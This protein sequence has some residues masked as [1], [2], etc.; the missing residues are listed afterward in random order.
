MTHFS[1][2]DSALQLGGE[3]SS[4]L[5]LETGEYVDKNDAAWGVPFSGGPLPPK[6]G[7]EKGGTGAVGLST[8][9]KRTKCGKIDC[10][11]GGGLIKVQK[12]IDNIEQVGGGQRGGI[13]TFSKNS[14]RRLMRTIAQVEKIE[15]PIFVTL[16]Y[17]GEFPGNPKEW[18]RHLKNFV[19]RLNYKFSGSSGI[20]K[21][22]PQKRG[23]PHYHLMIWGV[24]YFDLISYVPLAWYKVVGSDDIRHLHAGTRV[25]KVRSWRGVMG[26]ASKYLGKEVEN[27][28]GWEAVGRYWGVFARSSVP[29]AR[30]VT[31]D[32]DYRQ[33]V[34][35]IR[36]LRRYAHLKGRDYKSLTCFVNNPDF[37]FGALHTLLL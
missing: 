24:S 19:K 10:Y 2:L 27:L 21:L 5:D 15:L 7:T 32:L 31:V 22:E 34:N 6:G 35:L 14:R 8:A 30:L 1:I 11:L 23:A 33:A 26:Y 13:A 25:E 37:W 12:P 29:W 3:V 4:V 18:K 17:P 20:W 16:T 28:P 36:L 9:H